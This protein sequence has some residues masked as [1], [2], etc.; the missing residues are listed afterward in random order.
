LRVITSAAFATEKD[1]NI[2][3]AIA[4]VRKS[5]SVQDEEM[6]DMSPL[7]RKISTVS[8]PDTTLND[9]MKERFAEEIL[10]ETD[11]GQLSA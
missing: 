10:E 3:E 7:K 6:L 2:P 11:F 9:L 5:S 8:V 4:L 1:K